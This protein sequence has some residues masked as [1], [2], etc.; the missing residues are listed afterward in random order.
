MIDSFSGYYG[1]L[2]NFYLWCVVYDG[3]VYPS[4]EHAY[5]AAKTNSP[6]EKE[7]IKAALTPGTAKRL[8]RRATLIKDWDNL[9]VG[10]MEE[11]LRCKFS[12]ELLQQQLLETHPQELIEVNYWGDTFWGVH[13]EVGENNLGKL[14]MKIREEMKA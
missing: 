1:W 4:A 5:Q 11:I 12:D 6:L 7:Y 9:K 14:L 3:I 2:S 10:I 13:N 8:G